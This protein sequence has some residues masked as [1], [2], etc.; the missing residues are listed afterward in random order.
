MNQ[1]LEK[2]TKREKNKEKENRREK[3]KGRRMNR[4][5]F[6]EARA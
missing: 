4:M 6:D 5:M 3:G 2:E 1:D